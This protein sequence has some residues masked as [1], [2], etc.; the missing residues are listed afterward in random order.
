MQP[1]RSVVRW[2]R[3]GG[4]P[5]VDPERRP[6]SLVPVG[7]HETRLEAE[8]EALEE[9][10]N[11]VVAVVGAGGLGCR[12]TWRLVKNITH[13]TGSH[14]R[15]SVELGVMALAITPSA[16]YVT[17]THIARGKRADKDARARTT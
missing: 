14:R 13:T 8:A 5:T 15:R 17:T 7:I 1:V 3:L 9:V 12:A 6:G 2:L 4:E 16:L 11:L 10:V